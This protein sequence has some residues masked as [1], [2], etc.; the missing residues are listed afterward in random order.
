MQKP[1]GNLRVVK[2]N[3]SKRLSPIATSAQIIISDEAGVLWASHPTFFA[4]HLAPY[5][6]S[7][8]DNFHTW[9]SKV[10]AASDY[11]LHPVLSFE[12]PLDQFYRE[13]LSPEEAASRVRAERRKKRE[14]SEP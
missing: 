14:I 4:G 6:E 11:C 3:P 10:S 12:V 2:C 5:C 9:C 8:S 13:G 7:Q 1:S